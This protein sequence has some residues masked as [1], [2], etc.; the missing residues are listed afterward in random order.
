MQG[1]ICRRMPEVDFATRQLLD[2]VGRTIRK[3]RLGRRWSQRRLAATGACSQSEISRIERGVMIDLTIRRATRI[4]RALDIEPQL[5]LAVPRI[6]AVPQRD[7]AHARCVGAVARRL[8]KTGF[9]VAMEVEVG[10][11]R[12]R[13]WVDILAIHPITRLLLV[14]E[15]KTEL[16][17]LGGL[18]RQ[19]GSYMD[20]A[21]TAASARGWR[22][23]GATGVA[24]VLA[25]D[26]NDR[27]LRANRDLIDA[28][29]P[30]RTRMLWPLLNGST[31][32]LPPRG[33]RGLAMVDPASRRRVWLLPTTLDGRRT[34]APYADRDA[35]LARRR[36]GPPTP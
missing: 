1:T 32:H 19:L 5:N 7:R 17:D 29:Y 12:W 36:A 10:R 4:L 8:A 23:R 22:P 28:G 20:G 21:W 11:P 9:V 6:D 27:R 30:L 33:A 3:A 2:H 16:D 25:T 26:E 35:F 34:P 18:D 14:I 15:V 13:G 24:L 31:Q